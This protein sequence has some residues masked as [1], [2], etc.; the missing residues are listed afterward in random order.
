VSAQHTPFVLP[1]LDDDLREILGRPNFACAQ[2][3]QVLR[4][5]GQE[6]APKAEA[7]QAAVISWVLSQY[8]A[9]GADWWLHGRE[10]LQATIGAKEAAK[11]I[12]GAA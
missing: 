1:P 12:G 9:H 10:E 11:A 5:T 3:A 4:L 2:I 7:E 8:A 6:I